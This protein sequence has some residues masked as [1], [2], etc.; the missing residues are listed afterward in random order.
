MYE[1]EQY[2]NNILIIGNGFDI[3]HGYKTK[4]S[5]FLQFIIDNNF[6]NKA[7]DRFNRIVNNNCFINCFKKTYSVNSTWID[8]ENEIEKLTEMFSEIFSIL[9]NNN[10]VNKYVEFSELK[11]GYDQF[12]MVELFKDIFRCENR[13]IAMIGYEYVN[14]SVYDKEKIINKLQNLLDEVIEAVQIYITDHSGVDEKIYKK[15]SQISNIKADY[16]IN[17]NYTDTILE[18]DINPSNVVYV[19]GRAEDIKTMV[20]GT[21]DTNDD[22]IYFNKSFQ[23]LQ[24]WNDIIDYKKFE[25]RMVFDG[26]T[27]NV[28]HIY[29]HSLDDTDGDI[30]RKAFDKSEEYRIYYYNQLDYEN[31]IINLFKVFGRQKVC[32]WMEN[33]KLLPIKIE[34]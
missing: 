29:G 8:L 15:S 2:N 1:T 21:K 24:K 26:K 7:S 5:D 16:V 18:Y 27:R 30:L 4:Y 11:A 22:F 23:R 20:L 31:K 17:F 10:K 9:D 32:D 3:H 12:K 6:D 28:L 19:H 25:E 14:D 33:H 13:K 34:N